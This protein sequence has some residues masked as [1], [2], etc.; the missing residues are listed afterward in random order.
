[1]TMR[2]CVSIL[3]LLAIAV[4][5]GNAQVQRQAPPTANR[6]GTGAAPVPRTP[7]GQ[8]QRPALPPGAARPNIPG[9]S[10][11]GPSRQQGP[12]PPGNSAL[13]RATRAPAPVP[14]VP[15]RPNP[16]QSKLK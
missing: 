16:Q 11:N 10:P 3:L 5:I 8:A 4:S 13:P 14:N 2:N 1:M 15:S 6:P 7:P 12:A 9:P